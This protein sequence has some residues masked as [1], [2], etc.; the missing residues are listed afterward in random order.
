LLLLVS[1]LDRLVS[2]DTT[3][4]VK[5]FFFFFFFFA[6]RSCLTSCLAV[7]GTAGGVGDRVV[8]VGVLRSRIEGNKHAQRYRATTTNNMMAPNVKGSNVEPRIS[9]VGDTMRI[10]GAMERFLDQDFQRIQQG[11]A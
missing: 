6:N 10:R 3:S 4:M 11:L 5:V 8:C 7:A 1:L 9:R 2:A